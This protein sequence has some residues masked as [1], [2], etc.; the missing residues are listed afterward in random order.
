MQWRPAVLA[1]VVSLMLL[2]SSS[3]KPL[4]AS[5]SASCTGCS[6]ASCG[7][8]CYCTTGYPFVCV[9]RGIEF[10]DRKCVTNAELD[11]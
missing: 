10:P 7:P 5:A 8:E 2:G 3:S 6:N 11:P 1:P 9:Y 4:P